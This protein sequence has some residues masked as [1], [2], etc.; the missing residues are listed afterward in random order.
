MANY[1]T[2]FSFEIGD[3]TAEEARWLADL[4]PTDDDVSDELAALLTDPPRVGFSAEFQN[5]GGSLW[6]YA[7]ESGVPEDA[8]N[9][10]QEF[11]SRFRPHARHGFEWANTC[12]K[13]ILDAFGG[14]AVLITPND[15]H[16]MGSAQWLA[17]RQAE[18]DD[19]VRRETGDG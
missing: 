12:S 5:D 15:Q 6:I 4:I 17:D 3:L 9:L 14:G 2:L 7:E 1:L 10:V 13:P 16:W 11:L 8:A 19:T 18:A